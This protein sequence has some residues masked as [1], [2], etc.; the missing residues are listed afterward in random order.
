MQGTNTQP[1]AIGQPSRN[2]QRKRRAHGR[3]AVKG[4]EASPKGFASMT[5]KESTT[6]KPYSCSALSVP[7]SLQRSSNADDLQRA[8]EGRS[9]MPSGAR[10]LHVSVGT[11]CDGEA[12]CLT[13][14]SSPPCVKGG[15]TNSALGRCLLGSQ[16]LRAPSVGLGVKRSLSA[17]KRAR[18]LAAQAN[19]LASR[20][21]PSDG[22]LG[23]AL[24]LTPPWLCNPPETAGGSTQASCFTRSQSPRSYAHFVIPAP[25]PQEKRFSESASRS[26]TSDPRAPGSV[27]I[28]HS[29]LWQC[30]RLGAGCLRS[31]ARDS[32]GPERKRTGPGAM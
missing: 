3:Q 32:S 19:A 23:N 10:C 11:V 27:N 20:P 8:G 29:Q 30:R 17:I 13:P 14:G 15:R 24:L 1:K 12:A 4:H 9:A 5:P 31:L 7:T 6:H 25:C 26:V 18:P 2:D 16:N 28:L 21:S 22:E